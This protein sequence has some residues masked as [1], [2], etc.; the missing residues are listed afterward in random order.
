MVKCFIAL[1]CSTNED[2]ELFADFMLTDVFGQ[3]FGT[4]RTFNGFFLRGGCAGGDSAFSLWR[5][6]C[7]KIVSADTHRCILR[8]FVKC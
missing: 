5:N 6:G 3:V 8:V 2:F 4:K 7:G 1:F